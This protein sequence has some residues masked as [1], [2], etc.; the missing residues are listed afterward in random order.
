M[1]LIIDIPDDIKNTLDNA[2]RLSNRQLCDL[3]YAVS[4]ATQLP[5][6]GDLID[7]DELEPDCYDL[8]IHDGE[9]WRNE[10]C[11]VTVTQIEDAEVIIKAT[12]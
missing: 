4:E 11:G 2:E 1:Q 6:H 7:K 12:S 10:Y 5:K 8:E 9:D 3:L